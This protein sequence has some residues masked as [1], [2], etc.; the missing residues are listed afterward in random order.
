MTASG[1]R[2]VETR[3][4]SS[5]WKAKHTHILAAALDE[6]I[7][8]GFN[9]A[10]MDRI[11][12][13]ARVSKVTIYNHFENKDRLYRRTVDYYVNDVYPATP[14]VATGASPREVLIAYGTKLIE[15]ATSARRLGMIRLLRADPQLYAG[16]ASPN[17]EARLM[18]GDRELAIYLAREVTAGRVRIANADLAA[19][20]FVG[21]LFENTVYPL[22]LG[23]EVDVSPSS[24]QKIV[25]SCVTIF[26]GHYEQ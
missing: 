23:R 16:A 22:L 2:A 7:A 12:G 20:Q 26:L 3:R 4:E 13:K 9:G 11:A 25:D 8:C 21:M 18:P 14:P 5:A 17:G 24:V 10:S 19:R 15:T 6:F 1:A